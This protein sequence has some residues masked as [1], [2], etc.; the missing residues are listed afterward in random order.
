M[1]DLDQPPIEEMV[2]R[3]FQEDKA[4]AVYLGIEAA[5]I[6]QLE[7][8][9]PQAHRIQDDQLRCVILRSDHIEAGL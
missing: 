1:R 9:A 6:E 4:H 7:V 2:L 3:A 5:R 8:E